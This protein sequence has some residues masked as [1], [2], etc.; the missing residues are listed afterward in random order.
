[1]F[2][3]FKIFKKSYW[4]RAGVL[5]RTT[6]FFKRVPRYARAG[7]GK[8]VSFFRKNKAWF[9]GI[10]AGVAAGL[11]VRAISRLWEKGEESETRKDIRFGSGEGRNSREFR[12]Y[13]QTV[14]DMA[15]ELKY[16]SNID[17][18][19][20][21][22]A[23][24]AMIV[25]YHLAIV[26]AP[27]DNTVDFAVTVDRLVGGAARAGVTLEDSGKSSYVVSRFRTAKDNEETP[28]DI[29]HDLMKVLELDQ[30]DLPLKMA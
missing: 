16:T 29:S 26:N 25:H 23:F 8:F 7:W 24:S 15:T 9:A 5:G 4:Q 14:I 21:H 17:S 1:M 6:Q 3:I 11:I 13:L 18:D 10:G 27:T 30:L 19:L 2:S 20:A 12:A 22:G 28:A